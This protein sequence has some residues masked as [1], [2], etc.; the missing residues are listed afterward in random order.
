MT[1][2]QEES[3]LLRLRYRMEPT[4]SQREVGRRSGIDSRTIADLENGKREILVR[5][6]VA[7]AP[8]LGTTAPELM[9]E[10]TAWYQ[11]QGQATREEPS[12]AA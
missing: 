2:K 8:I 10:M 7:L 5:H 6:A 4:P 11:G 1:G 9:S 12:H 3:P